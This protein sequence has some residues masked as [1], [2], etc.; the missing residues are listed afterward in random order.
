MGRR[1][2]L[3]IPKGIKMWKQRLEFLIHEEIMKTMVHK[4]SCPDYIFDV[5]KLFLYFVI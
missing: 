1:C 5:I 3:F 2:G 4:G